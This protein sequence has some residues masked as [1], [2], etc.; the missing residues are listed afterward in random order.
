MREFLKHIT[1]GAAG[2]VLIVTMVP[3]R[4]EEP[5][6][7][8]ETYQDIEATLGA[9]PSFFTL[10]PESGI[11]GAWS[12]FKGIQLNPG[13]ALS[14]KEKELIGLAV[15]AQIPCE[16]CIYFHTKA[17]MLNGASEDEIK[18]AVAMAAIV[19]HWSTV[20]NGMQVDPARFRQELDNILAAAK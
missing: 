17:A 3:G 4:A 6:S 18:E 2:L 15:A 5:Q 1:A 7:A 20:L 12:E 16:Y 9:V 19:R 11:A 13:S 14:G 10:F 8:A